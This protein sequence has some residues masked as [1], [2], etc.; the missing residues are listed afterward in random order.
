MNAFL[1]AFN[2]TGPHPRLLE[3][4][5]GT[6]RMAV[7]LAEAGV[8][9]TGIDISPDMLGVLRGKR[10]DIDAL[11]AEAACP[12]FR[13]G[14]FDAALFVH[15]LHLVPDARATLRATF[16]LV[17]PGG[18]LIEG[19]DRGA[20]GV[21]GDADE[22]FRQA[23]KDV[24]GIDLWPEDI[25]DL[26]SRTFADEAKQVGGTVERRTV[27]RWSTVTTAARLIERLEKRVFSAA[28][29]ISD[30]QMPAMVARVAPQIVE[31]YGSRD[32]PVSSERSFTISIA[33]LPEA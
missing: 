10:R 25:Y 28:W 24:L 14:S 15:I 13:A 4:G 18:V 27:A 7:P 33:R 20:H 1:A 2:E 30:E 16:A 29:Q 3:I 9:I 11:F 6:G 21:R 31:L 22:I 32:G 26:P 17:R 19:G 23:G 5:I 8:H 12:P